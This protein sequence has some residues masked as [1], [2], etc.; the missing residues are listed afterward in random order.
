MRSWSLCR[1]M[2]SS[3]AMVSA[4]VGA[5]SRTNPF[6]AA[7][8]RGSRAICRR[9]RTAPLVPAAFGTSWI[10]FTPRSSGFGGLG[11]KQRFVRCMANRCWM[12]TIV[13]RTLGASS[14]YAHALCFVFWG[15]GEPGAYYHHTNTMATMACCML[16]GV[17]V[18]GPHL[19]MLGIACCLPVQCTRSWP[20]I[21]TTVFCSV[22]S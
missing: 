19:P 13:A 6:H 4:Q 11:V 14:R 9:K 1:E 7:P 5:K 8:Q 18:P 20:N 15:F 22:E 12:H 21:N 17:Q 2:C 3:P 10:P 16:L